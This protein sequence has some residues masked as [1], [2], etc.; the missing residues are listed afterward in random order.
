MWLEQA[1]A[2]ADRLNDRRRWKEC[3]ANLANTLY[4]QGEF[5]QSL[6]TFADLQRAAQRD[7]DYQALGWSLSGQG[8]NAV[9]LGQIDQALAWL[10]ARK[11]ML[12]STQNP[13]DFEVHGYLAA[14]YWRHGQLD[15]AEQAA[16]TAAQIIGP[17]TVTSYYSLAA[18]VSTAETCFALW[19]TCSTPN[20]DRSAIRQLAHQACQALHRAARIFPI[21]QPAAWLWQGVY[22]WLDGKPDRAARL[23]QKSLTMAESLA[24]PYEQAQAHYEIA[25]HLSREDPARHVH[26][27]RADTLFGRVRADYDRQRV[28]ALL[29]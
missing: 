14:A 13:L 5:E 25:R 18:C 11:A 24:M 7:G 21:G 2:I 26:L 8:Q 9:R 12:E 19:E 22:A 23:W 6:Q 15:L 4:C 29:T 16:R 28:Q 3:V 20:S 10:T 17:V 27:E 1:R